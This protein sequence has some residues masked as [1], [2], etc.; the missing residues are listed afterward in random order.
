[1]TGAASFAFGLLYL[2]FGRKNILPLIFAHGIFNTLGQTFRI[3]G[4][5][6]AD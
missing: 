5:V 6:D 4:I 3:L 1:M 2:W